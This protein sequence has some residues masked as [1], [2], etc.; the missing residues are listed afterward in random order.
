M[1]T[2]WRRRTDGFCCRSCRGAKVYTSRGRRCRRSPLW[3]KKGILV[4][5]LLMASL[6][7]FLCYPSPWWC[8]LG[9][10]RPVSGTTRSRLEGINRWRKESWVNDGSHRILRLFVASWSAVSLSLSQRLVDRRF[11]S[12]HDR[13]LLRTK[14]KQG[15]IAWIERY[16]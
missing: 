6:Q 11:E 3:M 8:A 7:I 14:R 5:V 12:D 15:I 1:R 4:L 2:E 9:S 13:A 16:R 10:R